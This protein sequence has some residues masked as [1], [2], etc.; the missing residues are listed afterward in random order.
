MKSASTPVIIERVDH[1]CWCCRCDELPIPGQTAVP[2]PTT[3]QRRCRPELRRH[4]RVRRT[5]HHHAADRRGTVAGMRAAGWRQGSCGSPWPHRRERRQGRSLRRVPG[6]D[7][8]DGVSNA[9]LRRRLPMVPGTP[10]SIRPFKFL[11]QRTTTASTAVVPVGLPDV[12]AAKLPPHT[13]GVGGCQGDP[14]GI[15]PVIVPA[16]DARRLAMRRVRI[17]DRRG[18]PRCRRPRPWIRCGGEGTRAATSP[19]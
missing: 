9:V 6:F 15:G 1:P 16:F 4:D 8:L 12:G 3:R 14:V 7:G 10:P 5:S 13:F 11:P 19:T 18:L 2:V 17:R